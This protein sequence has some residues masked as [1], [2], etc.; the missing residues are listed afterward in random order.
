MNSGIN[1]CRQQAAHFQLIQQGHRVLWLSHVLG[2]S[3]DLRESHEM[4]GNLHIT[5]L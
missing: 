4:D 5:T 2:I 3:Y 1:S